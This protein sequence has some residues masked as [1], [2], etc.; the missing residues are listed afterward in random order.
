[1][2]GSCCLNCC[3]AT[4]SDCFFSICQVLSPRVDRWCHPG[5]CTI[6]LYFLT[7]CMSFWRFLVVWTVFHPFPIVFFSI[8]R[9][10]SPRVDRWCHPGF[11][12][13]L[14]LLTEC[15][16]MRF[17]RFLVVWNVFHRFPIVFFFRFVE[18]HSAI[19][20]RGSSVRGLRNPSAKFKYDY[21]WLI[22]CAFRRF[23]VLYRKWSEMGTN[24]PSADFQKM[25][26]FSTLFNCASSDE[27]AED[28][29]G[30]VNNI[31]WGV[32]KNGAQ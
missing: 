21:E 7:V 14:Y 8:C 18:C 12:T 2:K 24:P 1:M 5:F 25:F 27:Q 31:W 26:T 4:F 20:A 32:Q 17:W 23:S 9:V 13:S 10:P 11:C 6:S 28:D 15:W 16:W 3:F 19:A 22:V 30:D 29:W